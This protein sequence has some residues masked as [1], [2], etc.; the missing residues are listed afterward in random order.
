MLILG[1]LVF[2]RGTSLIDDA[3][4]DITHSPYSHVVLAISDDQLIEAQGG[5]PVE[6]VPASKYVGRA[7][8]YRS[9]LPLETLQAIV[10][11]ASDY[12]G[13]P[14]GYALIVEELVREETGIQL[15]IPEDKHTICSVLVSDS[16]RRAGI[17]FCKGIE[18][19]A[20]SDE[21]KDGLYQYVFSY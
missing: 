17:A 19:P 8:V 14:Y 6:Y 12:L 15:P 2:V 18:Y 21:A 4:E 3:I 5:E 7:D 20:P 9:A 13:E 16:I 1:D 11:N 10:A